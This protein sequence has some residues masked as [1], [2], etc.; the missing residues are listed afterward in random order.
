MVSQIHPREDE[1]DS[2][3]KSEQ[4]ESH[5]AFLKL[6]AWKIVSILALICMAAIVL[7]AFLGVQHAKNKNSKV[8]SSF[9]DDRPDDIFK[10]QNETDILI[11]VTA[12]GPYDVD[13][14]QQLGLL[15]HSSP[16]SVSFTVHVGS[17][18]NHC[19]SRQNIETANMLK[20]TSL[21]PVFVVPG[22]YDWIECPDPRSAWWDWEDTYRFFDAHWTISEEGHTM[23]VYYQRNVLE[24]WGFVENGVLFLGV[25]ILNGNPPDENG[26]EERNVYNFRW[27]QGMILE[28]LSTIHAVVV[29]GNASPRY[30]G[31][32]SFFGALHE[33][34]RDFYDQNPSAIPF[35]YVHSSSGK[36]E[37]FEK[38]W[39]FSDLKNNVS[40]SQFDSKSASSPFMY[41]RIGSGSDP[42]QIFVN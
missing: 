33:F 11:Q 2:S 24:N 7:G 28:H 22:Q 9:V 37:T 32:A 21:K 16:L 20:S 39:P 40:A 10:V 41:V 14:R 29:F 23:L 13:S 12:D 19:D 1:N 42:F 27:V 38:Y 25:H 8:E 36:G 15:L 5:H 34:L 3:L 30:P 18:G 4:K 6:H 31:N 17:L 35:H 26:H